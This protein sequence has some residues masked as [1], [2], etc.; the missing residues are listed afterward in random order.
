MKVLSLKLKLI[1]LCFSRVHLLFH[2]V[3][4]SRIL[5]PYTIS[6][7]DPRLHLQF[8]HQYQES[9]LQNR[10]SSTY[11][12]N[13]LPLFFC[14]HL[15]PFLL[16]FQISRQL[17]HYFIS[18]LHRLLLGLQCPA[19]PHNTPSLCCPHYLSLTGLMSATEGLTSSE[20]HFLLLVL[21]DKSFKVRRLTLISCR[22]F[23]SP[24]PHL[25]THEQVL[26]DT[27]IA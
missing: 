13:I 9:G 17:N 11:F 20:L 6:L 23:R 2:V 10:V 5:I 7:R 22:L 14:P 1:D 21:Q 19:Y 12:S 27:L 26:A 16:L 15:D 4:S 24:P 3:T 8:L 18:L 25:Q